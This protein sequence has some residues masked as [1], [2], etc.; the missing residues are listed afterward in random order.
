[1]SRAT[2]ITSLLVPIT[3]Y[4]LDSIHFRV[5]KENDPTTRDVPD[6]PRGTPAVMKCC[7][8]VEQAQFLSLR[9]NLRVMPAQ[10]R[11]IGPILDFVMLL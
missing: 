11:F 6:A 5:A 7:N 8:W 1:M 4:E 10:Q 2:A 9:Q 3:F